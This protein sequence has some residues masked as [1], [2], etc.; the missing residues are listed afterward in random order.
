MYRK[1]FHTSGY[2]RLI[3]ILLFALCLTGC[4]KVDISPQAA[5]ASLVDSS[6]PA[7]VT[8]AAFKATNGDPAENEAADIDASRR[9]AITRAVKEVSPAVVN[10]TV[11]EVVKG[12]KPVYREFGFMKFFL[13][14]RRFKRN[15]KSIGSGFIISEEGLVVTNAHVANESAKKIIVTLSDGS[16]YKAKVIGADK[17]SDIAVLKIKADREFPYVEFA[18]S[19]KVIVGEWAIAIGN[20]FGLFEKSRPSVT[21]GVV[22]AVHRDFQPNPNRPRVYLDMIQTDAAINAGNSGGPLVNSAGKVIGI[23]TFIY[24]GGTGQGFVGLGFA[25]PSNRA[26]KIIRELIKDGDY[27]KPFDLGW[28]LNPTTYRMIIHN[29][30]VRL[31]AL[32]VYSVNRNGP[33]FKAGIIPG[34]IILKIGDTYVQSLMHAKALLRQ[35]ELGDSLRVEFMRDGHRY[36]TKIYLRARVEG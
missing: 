19:E 5:S 26:K 22:S 20:P 4:D 8:D 9:N 12:A 10:I 1:I 35:Y 6:K 7:N 16:Q 28:N 2:Y 34:D 32:S 36:E 31:P 25:I 30:I 14:Y 33:A 21:V 17:L 3:A 15:V 23:N 29:R 18:N 11:T 27:D 13:G 24:T